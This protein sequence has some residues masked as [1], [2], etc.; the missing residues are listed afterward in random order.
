M[1]ARPGTHTLMH[2]WLNLTP[3]GHKIESEGRTTAQ[4]ISLLEPSRQAAQHTD[5]TQTLMSFQYF[6]RQRKM[7][8]LDPLPTSIQPA[9]KPCSF[10]AREPK[11]QYHRQDHARK[12]RRHLVEVSGV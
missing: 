5:V 3:G 9:G 8:P 12:M 6:H 4:Y 2:Y 11:S 10:S 7:V 1:E